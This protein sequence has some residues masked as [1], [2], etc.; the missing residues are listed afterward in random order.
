GRRGALYGNGIGSRRWAE[1]GCGM[2]RFWMAVG[3]LFG[4]GMVAMAAFAA[5]G[6]DAPA[7]A[8]VHSGVEMQ[9]WHAL[10]LL[11][12]G[13]WVP[14]GGRLAHSAGAAFTLGTLLFCGAVY[15]VGL[16]GRHLGPVAPIGGTLLMLG[17]GLLA[18][19]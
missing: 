16:F 15:T 18:L 17:W 19:S 3:A 2:Q 1:Q 5:H 10:A 4:L 8:V 13:L 11:A 9:G 14:R 12:V 7:A 6:L